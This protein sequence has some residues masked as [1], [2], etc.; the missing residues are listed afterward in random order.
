M[1]YAYPSWRKTEAQRQATHE[2]IYGAG[3]PLPA[4]G[5][6]IRQARFGNSNSSTL[7]LLLLGA[8]ALIL[9]LGGKK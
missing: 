1:S 6:K 2:A 8:G 5:Y 4:R 9:L 3:S 7:V